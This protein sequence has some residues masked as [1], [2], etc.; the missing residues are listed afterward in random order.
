MKPAN[1][2]LRESIAARR[3]K[4]RSPIKV[5]DY[6]SESPQKAYGPPWIKEFL[7]KSGVV[8]GRAIELGS[9]KAS[10]LQ[11]PEKAVAID[12]SR[13][14]LS[15]APHGNKIQMNPSEVGK[16]SLPFKDA[17]FDTALMPFFINY[18]PKTQ[19]AFLKDVQRVLKKDGRMVFVFY[20]GLHQGKVPNKDVDKAAL[21]GTLK[22]MGLNVATQHIGSKFGIK[23]GETKPLSSDIYVTVASK[24][25]V[26]KKELKQ[27]WEQVK[28]DRK[29]RQ[30][31]DGI[32]EDLDF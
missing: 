6:E 20:K 4:N 24:K 3:A 14:M 1:Q 21:E 9:G 26:S 27:A 29:A 7:E 18:I 25:A 23:G 10:Y 11:D 13:G 2:T 30:E 32:F 8:K 31:Y 16:K 22:S 12:I 19:R 28:K 5:W 17:S 15:Q